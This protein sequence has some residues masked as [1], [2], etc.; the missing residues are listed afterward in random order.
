MLYGWVVYIGLDAVCVD[1]SVDDER[2]RERG[3]AQGASGAGS[4]G[5]TDSRQQCHTVAL[6]NEGTCLP[7]MQTQKCK[8]ARYI[9]EPNAQLLLCIA[10]LL[11]LTEVQRG[12]LHS[13]T[14]CSVASLHCRPVTS[15]PYST[16]TSKR[17]TVQT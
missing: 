3:G 5:R 6:P 17:E 11:H 8:E 10:V 4:I 1:G 9:P 14:E 16:Y 13:R 12:A 15:D 2:R 7:C